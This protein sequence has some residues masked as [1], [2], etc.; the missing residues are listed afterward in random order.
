MVRIKINGKGPFN[1]IVDTGAPAVF[2]GTETAKKVGLK[3]DMMGWSKVEKFEVE[4]GVNL[5]GMKVRIEDPFQLI[6]MNKTNM[7]GIRYDGIL[8]YT[9]LAKFR[10]EYDFARPHLVWTTLDWKPPAPPIMGKMSDAKGE[11]GMMVGMSS[12][13]TSLIPR[14]VDPEIVYRGFIGVEFKQVGETVVV[15]SIYPDSPAQ[16]AGLKVD[17]VVRQV[18]EATIKNAADLQKMLSEA[19]ADSEWV[20]IIKRGE[21]EEE[22][23]IK[24][25]RG[26]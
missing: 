15:K 3:E 20:F 13:A 8:G 25:V 24:A 2:V 21:K 22:V 12:L 4:G 23:T 26:F 1:F 18:K 11:M 5:D 14:K 9:A 7:G 19:K 10:I 17:D 6:G 16:L